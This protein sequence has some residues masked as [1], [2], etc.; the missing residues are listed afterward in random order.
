MYFET[1][2]LLQPHIEAGKLAALAV[3][4]D[5]RLPQLSAVPTTAESGFPKLRATFWS[6]ILAPAGTPT[7]VISK[8]NTAINDII[9]TPELEA[10]LAKLSARSKIGSPQDFADFMAAEQKKWTEIA[11]AAG[12]KVK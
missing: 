3:A 7:S 6:G 2:A 12:I 4:D 9:R 11:D 8:L 1:A 5:T 10:S